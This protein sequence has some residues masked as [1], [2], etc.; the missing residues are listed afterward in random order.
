MC[1][2]SARDLWNNINESGS[3]NVIEFN[4]FLKLVNIDLEMSDVEQVV[5]I[6]GGK[7]NYDQF[8]KI[9]SF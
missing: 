4:V 6:F 1:K 5:R 9:I 7:I 8:K 2:M 3:L